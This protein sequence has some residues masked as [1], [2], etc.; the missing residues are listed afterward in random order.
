[1]HSTGLRWKTIDHAQAASKLPTDFLSLHDKAVTRHDL[2]CC[3]GELIAVPTAPG[4]ISKRMKFVHCAPAFTQKIKAFTSKSPW[5][6]KRLKDLL[7]KLNEAITP[8]GW[9]NSD[10]IGFIAPVPPIRLGLA[11]VS[12]A[13]ERANLDDSGLPHSRGARSL[14]CRSVQPCRVPL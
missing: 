10:L 4:P 8:P 3:V 13:P 14:S 11:D 2:S 7:G 12:G 5:N 6:A 9:P 1:M